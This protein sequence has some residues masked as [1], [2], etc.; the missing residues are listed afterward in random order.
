MAAL[1][2][3]VQDGDILVEALGVQP[4]SPGQLIG[5]IIEARAQ[6]GVVG[7]SLWTSCYGTDR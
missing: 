5:A 7:S 3:G 4:R 1:G 2:I 6:L